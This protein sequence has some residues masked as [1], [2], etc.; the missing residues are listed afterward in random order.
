MLWPKENLFKWVTE[1]GKNISDN[2]CHPLSPIHT[3]FPLGS[4]RNRSDFL[5]SSEYLFSSIGLV[6]NTNDWLLETTKSLYTCWRIFQPCE[7]WEVARQWTTVTAKPSPDYYVLTSCNYSAVIFLFSG[8]KGNNDCVFKATALY[9]SKSLGSNTRVI[10]SGIIL[11][12][13]LQLWVHLATRKWKK[14]A[15]LYYFMTEDV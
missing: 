3:L 5:T 13:A 12:S 6:V 8:P 15:A 2:V 14:H 10:R 4:H 1:T 11:T 7:P 9:L